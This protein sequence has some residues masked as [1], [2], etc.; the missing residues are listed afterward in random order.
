MRRLRGYFDVGFAVL[1]ERNKWVLGMV[2]LTALAGIT[3]G[4]FFAAGVL[5]GG[6][7]PLD[8]QEPQANVAEETP[9]PVAPIA[10]KDA[11]DQAAEPAFIPTAIPYPTVVALIGS[12]TESNGGPVS[13]LPAPIQVR[14]PINLK[15]ASDLG[16]LEFV[17]VY[18]P[19]TMEFVGIDPGVL[20]ADAVIE[21]KLRAPGKVW[22]GMID[23]RGINGDGSIAVVSFRT[24]EGGQADSPLYL[25]EISS[26]Y[27]STLLD[28][29]SR[30]TP[31]MLT[32][33]DGWFSSPTLIVLSKLCGFFLEYSVPRMN[34]N[35]AVMATVVSVSIIFLFIKG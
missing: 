24:L 2:G 32:A 7:N 33:K 34:I 18:E 10:R 29:P 20:A 30:P 28:A 15:G 12:G 5:G 14:V 3:V 11:A 17:L 35:P 26:H 21:T 6:E 1:L 22:V 9:A 25:E 19:A 4:V 23:P 27:A 8:G 16:S 13:D 31:G